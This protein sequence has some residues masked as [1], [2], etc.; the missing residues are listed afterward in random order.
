MFILIYGEYKTPEFHTPLTSL[1]YAILIDDYSI[2][3]GKVVIQMDA[4]S[5]PA[6]L[7]VQ[8]GQNVLESMRDL[9]RMIK[10]KG[11]ER[12]GLYERFCANEHSFEVY[13]YMDAAVGQ[14]AEVQTFQETLDTFSSIFTEIRTNF[15]A[16]VDV[17]QAEDAY[18]KACQAYKAMAESLGF[19][20]EAT[21]IK[22]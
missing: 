6:E 17:K 18:G 14:L 1:L 7:L 22:S 4:T 19:A 15:E 21:T 8:Q 2:K 12:S 13:T 5:K 9:R 10:K 3:F 20:K 11:K 16:D